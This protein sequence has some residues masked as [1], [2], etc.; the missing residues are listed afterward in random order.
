MATSITREEMM[1]YTSLCSWRKNSHT[2]KDSSLFTNILCVGFG[3]NKA[4]MPN[5]LESN[6]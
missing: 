5:G 1:S 2:N 4:A 6:P 3:R